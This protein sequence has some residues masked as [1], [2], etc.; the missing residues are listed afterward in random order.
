[1][2][3]TS[4]YNP[5]ENIQ[6]TNF[7]TLSR[8]VTY[9][10]QLFS[11]LENGS[12]IIANPNFNITGNLP[13]DSPKMRSCW[14]DF[15]LSADQYSNLKLKWRRRQNLYEI[16]N[17]HPALRIRNFCTFGGDDYQIISLEIRGDIDDYHNALEVMDKWIVDTLGE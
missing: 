17:P 1:M 12:S 4:Q 5:P 16:Q 13:M 7:L 15:P 14:I 9:L 11:S 2:P 8:Q 10:A 3:Y 6:G